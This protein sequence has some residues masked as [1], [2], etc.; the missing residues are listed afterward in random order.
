MNTFDYNWYYFANKDYIGDIEYNKKSIYEHYL[1]NRTSLTL[2]GNLF[3]ALKYK[4]KSEP[5]RDG[6]IEHAYERF[7]GYAIHRLKYQLKFIC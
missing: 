3:H 6:M 2:S 4:T 5:I 7:F 1:K